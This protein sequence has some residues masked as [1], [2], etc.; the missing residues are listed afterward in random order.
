MDLTENKQA[1]KQIPYEVKDA[2][3]RLNIKKGLKGG[4]GFEFTV[5]GDTKD[6]IEL[7]AN[8]M[9]NYLKAI[10]IENEDDKGNSSG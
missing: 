1:E 3:Y 2:N 7:R 8:A 9:R 5:R 4:Y 10:G 6:E